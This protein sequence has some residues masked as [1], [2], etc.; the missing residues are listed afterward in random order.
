MKSL[1]IKIP[2]GIAKSMDDKARLNPSWIA[3]FLIINLAKPIYEEK[4][5][6]LSYNYTFKIDK[7]LHKLIKLKAIEHDLPINE[8]VAR[9]LE[10]YYK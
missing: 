7:E 3:G 1:S 10:K 5:K 6:G 4:V 2:L 8:F 9:L